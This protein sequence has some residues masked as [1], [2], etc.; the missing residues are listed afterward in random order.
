MIDVEN[1]SLQVN[2]NGNGIQNINK[3]GQRY[4]ESEYPTLTKKKC[5]CNNL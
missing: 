4:G 2:D 3:I 5:A 1:F